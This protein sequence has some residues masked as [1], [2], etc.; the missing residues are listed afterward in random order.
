MSES[1]H[2]PVLMSECLT[3]LEPKPGGRFI[4]CTVNGGGHSAALLERTAPD[5]PLLG[6]D[7]DPNA[8]PAAT[9]RLNPYGTRVTLIQT[10]F[11]F[12]GRVARSEGFG[13][14]DGVLLDLGL[15]SN[16][17]DTP[18]RGFSFN[19][20]EPLDMRFDPSSGISAA[21]Y[22]AAASREDIEH[23]LRTLGEEPRA[24]RIAANIVEAR[25]DSPI[26]TTGQLARL[27]SRAVGGRHGRIHP[28]TRVF[29]ALRMAVNDEL[30]ALAEALP[31]ALTLLRHGGRLAVISFHSLEDRLVKT[32][33]R[34]MAGVVEPA[35]RGIPII[36]VAP[37]TEM[38]ILTRRPVGA[39]ADEVAANPRSRSARLRVAERL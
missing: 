16:Q 17:L 37:V 2:V 13:S 18:G 35:P 24:R 23:T 21:Q 38:R 7:A 15:S 20:D 27:V 10:N 28:A 6:L 12:V 8:M 31:Q 36:P 39:A 5:G 4:D 22:V 29:Q 30:G 9:S 1:H 26:A 32:F 25:Q 14:V 11:R 33:L 19:R 3:L 34:H